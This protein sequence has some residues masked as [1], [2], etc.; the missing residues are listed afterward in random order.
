LF[1][2]FDDQNAS[3]NT[4][5]SL[6]NPTH[7]FEGGDKIYN[8]YLRIS[9][10]C[11]DTTL[12]KE[13]AVCDSVSSGFGFVEG[14]DNEV[15]FSNISYGSSVQTT[16]F[17]GTGD[18]LV[19]NTANYQFPEESGT[20]DVCLRTINLCQDTSIYCEEITLCNNLTA[21]FET[22]WD[23]RTILLANLSEGDYNYLKWDL[24]NGVIVENDEFIAYTYPPVDHSYTVCL[25]V[26]NECGE[27]S[28][29][30]EFYVVL[31]I[32]DEF[33]LE[34]FA[35]M[36]NPFS[37][38]LTLSFP[39]SNEVEIRIITAEGRL[40]ETYHNFKGELTVNTAEWAKGM[41]FIEA[42]NKSASKVIKL[43]K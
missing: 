36:P 2:F 19:S 10:Q 35:A 4:T 12:S 23:D 39:S 43:V 14:K 40:I 24:G 1:W 32:E 7:L 5:S 20:Y 16:W 8:V 6:S 34:E 17:F 38:E 21:A 13:V 11:G 9:N 37:D 18:S 28:S 22:Q 42:Q 30:C 25:T 41:Y 33:E 26:E 31:G 29:D 3:Q 27:V 15:S